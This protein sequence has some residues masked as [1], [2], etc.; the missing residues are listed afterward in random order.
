MSSGSLR[1][2]LVTGAT[3][4]IGSAIAR[5]LHADGYVVCVHTNSQ[6]AVAQA[7]VDSLGDRA[8]VIHGDVERDAEAIVTSCIESA[9]RID[10]LI[11]NAAVQP[12][13]GLLSLT[14]EEVAEVV[15]VNL[16]GVIAMTRAA[17]SHM[18]R[19]HTEGVVCN[20]ASIEAFDAPH[21]HSHYAATKAAVVQHTR[22]VAV[23]LG[24]FGI[25]S[26]G[27]APGL[28]EREGLRDAWPQ[29]VERWLAASPLARL[30]HAD[31]IAAAVA[32]LVS[33]AAS[34]ITG[35]TVIVDG[36][37]TARSPWS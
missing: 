23:E 15:R 7:L 35:T 5:H 19:A 29:G 28:V 25:R 31:D 20:I 22:A 13:G 14:S 30:G 9:G 1:V 21:D 33:P 24:Q 26:V 3:G 11:N 34:W 4:G 10:V 17:T 8:S 6:L 37:M 32:F 18:V 36:G 27:V 12:V 16:L 2:A